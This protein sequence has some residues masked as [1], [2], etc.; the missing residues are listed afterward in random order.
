VQGQVREVAVSRSLDI[1]QSTQMVL[2]EGF[3]EFTWGQP[4]PDLLPVT[5]MRR[6]VETG[7]A[8]YGPAALSYGAAEGAWPLLGWIRERVERIEGYST[9]LD[10]CLGT[11][12]N[13][14]ALDQICTLF[15]R[16][17]DVAL[18]ESPTYH[19]AL[20]IMHDHGL[21]LHAVPLD[22][23]GLDVGALQTTLRSLKRAGKRARL[24]YTIPTFHNPSGVSLTPDRRRALV[25]LAVAEDLLIVEDDVYRELVYDGSA[26]PSLFG[27]APR[28]TVMRMGSFAKTLAPGLRLGWLN[29]SAAQV[30]RIADGGLRDSG[31]SPSFF[32]GM[33]VAAL[34]R[35]GDYDRQVSRLVS[36]YRS[37]RDALASALAEHLPQGCRFVSPSGGFFL[38][39][40]LPSAVDAEALAPRAEAH[41]VTFIP[42]ARFCIDGRGTNCLR[43][44]FSQMKPEALIAGA[45]RLAAALKEAR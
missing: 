35:S 11:A 33:M 32:T 8:T 4:D 30:R 34:C 21:D 42:G 17:G 44:A 16:P 3:C 13:S 45:R 29:A 19:L 7:L 26:P 10:E 2:R 28:G 22:D 6:A 24:L 18:V 25:D 20:R 14:D 9:G 39:V 40:S 41:N 23:D 12:G 38:W 5:E 15:T 31:G 1:P 43:L 36:A 37:R 27:L